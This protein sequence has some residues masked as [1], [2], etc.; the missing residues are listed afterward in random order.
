[1]RV[2]ADPAYN[3]AMVSTT[4]R[5]SPLVALGVAVTLL[6]AACGDDGGG[7]GLSLEGDADGER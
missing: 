3:G 5:R 1:M 7:S 6:L 2:R 4:R